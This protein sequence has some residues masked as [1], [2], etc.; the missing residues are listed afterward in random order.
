[1][2]SKKEKSKWFYVHFVENCSPMLKRFKTK[3]LAIEFIENLKEKKNLNYDDN[4]FDFLIEG[5]LLDA[6]DYYKPRKK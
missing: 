6:S 4:W 5:D 3:S 2:K 1:M